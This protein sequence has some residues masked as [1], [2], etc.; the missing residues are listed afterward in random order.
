MRYTAKRESRWWI[1]IRLT[2]NL[3]ILSSDMIIDPTTAVPRWYRTVIQAL[4]HNVFFSVDFSLKITEIW[5]P[6]FTL[7]VG[8]TLHFSHEFI[9][10]LPLKIISGDNSGNYHTLTSICNCKQPI[11]HKHQEDD[12]TPSAFCKYEL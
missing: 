10:V 4:L 5:D 9:I 6:P 12:V 3:T 2:G 11:H 7:I 8:N 1:L